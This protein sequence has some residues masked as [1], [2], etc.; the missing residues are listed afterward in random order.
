MISFSSNP[1]KCRRTRSVAFS[2]NE[3]RKASGFRAHPIV[4]MNH[5]SAVVDAPLKR[6][7][8][9]QSFHRTNNAYRQQTRWE[10]WSREKD[11]SC[12][13]NSSRLASLG[14]VLALFLEGPDLTDALPSP[15]IHN[16]SRLGH[17]ACF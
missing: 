11:A 17:G 7:Q 15:L 13:G 16:F 10:E 2:Q 9:P 1:V 4:Q 14:S 3:S 6:R 5:M 8:I 12:S